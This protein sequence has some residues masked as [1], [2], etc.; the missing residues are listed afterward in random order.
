MYGTRVLVCVQCLFY[1]IFFHEFGDF[2]C[3]VKLEK[4]RMKCVYLSEIVWR[5]HIIER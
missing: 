5:G 1:G 2:S 4:I 3:E